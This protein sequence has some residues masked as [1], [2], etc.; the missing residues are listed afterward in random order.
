MPFIQITRLGGYLPGTLQIHCAATTT[1]TMKKN[2]IVCVILFIIGFN[3]CTAQG[4][5]LETVKVT[6]CIYVFKPKIDYVHGNGIAIIGSDG[7]F[8]IDTYQAFTYADE[9]IALLKKI[10]KLPVK[11][12]LN[13]HWHNDH[14]M[15]ND[16]FKKAFPGCEII[17]QDS[18]YA[19]MKKIVKPAV[20]SDYS[21]T[22]QSI[23]VTEKQIRDKKSPRGTV[24][25]PALLTYWQLTLDEA[26]EYVKNFKPYRFVNGD[27]TFS[28]SLTF[29]WGSQ[30]LK[31]SYARDNGH[32]EGDV[33]VW[34]PEKRIAITGDIVV[35]PTPYATH[36]N[37]PGMIRAIQRVIDM[38][39]AIIIP[40]HGVVQYNLAYVE[41]E[42][43]AF[44]AYWDAAQAAIKNNTPLKEAMNNVSVPDIDAQLT[45]DDDVKKWALRSYFSRF[46]VYYAYTQAGLVPKT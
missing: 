39:P 37:I 3:Y 17:M 46:I 35:A 18:T 25:T 45:G 8:F 33:M 20:D 5:Y 14:V 31:L 44:I 34:I 12:V 4:K 43:K 13:T 22:L 10:T 19:Y 32:S 36:N 1:N 26:K 7:V 16:E 2:A 24:L 42:K 15:G 38:Q 28:D 29:H 6:D 40:G 11:Y 23:P 41:L 9:A 27:I 21:S 30:T